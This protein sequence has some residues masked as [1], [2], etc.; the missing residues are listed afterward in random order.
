MSSLSVHPALFDGHDILPNAITR[1]VV[2]L[3]TQFVC[4]QRYQL[5]MAINLATLETVIGFRR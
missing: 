5:S 1:G 3:S 4:E 2:Q